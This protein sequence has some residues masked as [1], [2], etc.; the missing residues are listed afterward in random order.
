MNVINLSVGNVPPGACPIVIGHRGENDVTQVVLD[1]SPWMQEFGSGVVSLYMKR[2]GDTAAYPVV[3]TTAA[4]SAAWTVSATDTNVQ[5]LGVAEYVYTIDEQIKKSAVF[6]VFIDRDIGQPTGDPPDPYESWLEQL[7]ALGA[8]TQQNAQDAAASATTAQTA[9]GA[10]EIAQTAAE[11]AQQAAETA[12]S[13]YPQIQDSYWYVWDV[14]TG[15]FV[16]TGIQAKGEDGFS[17]TVEVTEISGGHRVTITDADGPHVFDVMDGEIPEIDDA[18][19]ETSEN[20]VQN[21][22]ITQ[23]L[24]DLLPTDTASGAIASF[25]DGADGVPMIS[26]VADIDT[27]QDLHGYDAPWPAGGGANKYD[28]QWTSGRILNPD[29]TTSGTSSRGVTSFIPVVA[30]KS[31]CYVNKDL[32]SAKGRAAFYDSSYKLVEYLSDFPT[33]ITTATDRLYSVFTV[34]PGASYLMI[35]PTVAYGKDYKNDIAINYPATVTTFVPYS[36]ICPISGWPGATV[37]RTGKN[38]ANDAEFSIEEPSWST[39]EYWLGLSK[40]ADGTFTLTRPIGWGGNGFVYVGTYKAGTYKLS[41]DLISTA[42]VNC[43]ATCAIKKKGTW[44]A[45][46]PVAAIS[47]LTVAGRYSL[48]DFTITEDCDVWLA[49]GPYVDNGAQV[50]SGNYQVELGSTTS[51]YEPYQG[52]T[53]TIQLGQNVYGGTLDVTAGTLT[54]THIIFNR[55]S[56]T[57]NNS[58]AYPG[59]NDA[60]L[61]ALGYTGSR[62]AVSALLNIGTELSYNCDG[63]NDILFFGTGTYHKTQEEWKALA[64]DI[65]IVI[66]LVTPIEI[67]L[68]PTQIDTLLG[69][70]NIWSDTGSVSVTYRADIQKYIEK[71]ISAAVAA[72]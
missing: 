24:Y 32:N 8:E 57:M 26:L 53:Y 14:Q 22:V 46:G 2:P 54:V 47:G 62:S 50:I 28:Q 69:M 11:A 65:Q 5:G 18:L 39:S 66:P 29:G 64:L 1:F 70:N 16:N 43:G 68:T 13:H 35:S 60:G 36:N 63:S 55:N 72:L 23:A 38:L 41:F 40:N 42:D 3:L 30:G 4:G 9:Q 6:Q 67:T 25:P 33:T 44:T 37:T 12:A 71:K 52:N 7:Q 49:V 34:P 10:A 58:N 51:A 31:Y 21:K 19:S 61:K 56:S 48:N 20:P 17:P 15:T 27:N 59:W 45:E